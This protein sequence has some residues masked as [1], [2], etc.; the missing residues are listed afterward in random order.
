MGYL[1]TGRFKSSFPEGIEIEVEAGEGQDD[2]PNGPTKVSKHITGLTEASADC[3]VVVFSDVDF[4]WDGLAYAAGPFRIKTV[5]GDN[6]ALLM[7]AIE[8]LSGSGD[9]IS[10][11]SRGNFKR[12]FTLVDEIERKADEE[13]AAEIEILKLQIEKF[14]EER[15]A[16]EATVGEG[17]DQSVLDSTIVQKRRDIEL[18]IRDAQRHLRNVQAKRRENTE[19]L[20]NRLRYVNVLL[21][22]SLV[23]LAAVLLAIH[24]SARARGYVPEMSSTSFLGDLSGK[25]EHAGFPV[26]LVALLD[27]FTCGLFTLIW[28]GL[29]HGKLPRVRHN[30]PGALRA[31]LFMLIPVFNIYWWLFSH[32]RLLARVDEQ[33]IRYSLGRGSLVPLLAAVWASRWIGMLLISLGAFASV[34]DGLLAVIPLTAIVLGEAALIS[35]IV[36]QLVFFCLLQGRVNELVRTVG[37][38]EIKL[39]IVE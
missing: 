23:L 31:I 8:D 36:L 30:D 29:L 11:R 1:L 4:I 24:A 15:E 38:R 16:L 7:D 18:K 33:R 39:E 19:Q 17:A 2:D 10:I 34:M 26:W 27:I 32:Y 20:G 21:V 28:F 14:N 22:P 25:F 6:A 9:L 3:A 5:R 35:S 37:G 13:T 12:P